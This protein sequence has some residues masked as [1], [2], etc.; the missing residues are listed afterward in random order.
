MNLETLLDTLK[1]DPKLKTA[2]EWVSMLSLNS[3]DEVRIFLEQI[4]ALKQ[5][6]DIVVTQK[7][8]LQPI[9]QSDFIVGKLS[10]NLKGFG[11]VDGEKESI[12]ISKF[13]LKDAMHG[14]KVLVKPKRFQD[15]STEG[16]IIKVIERANTKLVAKVIV[17]KGKLS[18]VSEDNRIASSLEIL[19]RGQ[20]SLVDGQ[21]VI[22]EI[23]GYGDPLKVKVIQSLGHVD[24]PGIDITAQ[25]V[26]HDVPR[27]FNESTLQQVNS[28]PTEVTEIELEGR[29]DHR[30]KLVFTID[31]EDA[32]DFDDAIAIETKGE[33]TLL[34][35]HIADVSHYVSEHSP[36]DESAYERG[37]SIYL[38]DRVVPMLPH[39]LSN[40]ICSLMEGVDR[41]TLCCKMEINSKAEV[42]DYAIY[43]SVIRSSKR[44]TY[45]QVNHVLKDEVFDESYLP[46]T[47]QLKAMHAL[48]LQIRQKRSHDGAIDFHSVESKFILNKKRNI[49]DITERIQDEAEKLIEDFM[50]LANETVA[51]HMMFLDLPAIYRVHDT[52]DEKRFG[53]FMKVGRFFGI[54]LKEKHVSA[55]S[56]Q[57]ILKQFETH[58]AF[59]LLNDL[60][61]RSMAKA[62]Y[63]HR[64][65]GHFGLGLKEYCHFTSPIRRYP[66]L[67]VHRM[68]RKHVFEFHPQ[69]L[70][71]DANAVEAM[72][73][74][75]SN[76]EVRAVETERDVEAMKK[77]EFMERHVGNVYTGLISSVTKFGFFVRLE[78][79]VEGLVHVSNLDGY[80]EFNDERYALFKR[81]SNQ[82]YRLGQKVRIRVLAASKANQTIDFIVV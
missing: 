63:D 50:V 17:K 54:K 35:V 2:E 48:A 19:D 61:I 51:K 24:D 64:C 70:E 46:F 82:S 10:I 39:T 25:L 20:S 9:E 34:Y 4:E 71:N 32:K 37:T 77:A 69:D 75:C 13:N 57:S 11:F 56:I 33:N 43:P 5:N 65:L 67:I 55:K 28:I 80:Y 79:T 68:L 16:E 42:V 44:M 22:C 53:N 74:Q 66:D 31:G 41:L 36:L 15:G 45:T 40:G 1:K 78:N 30:N 72:A 7:G 49:I 12:Y 18:L 47:T 73:K 59:G 81:G 27:V 60:L 38:V 52:P 6:Y 23:I 8:K 14:D 29:I 3:V 76:T 26:K 58:E 62:V 21:I